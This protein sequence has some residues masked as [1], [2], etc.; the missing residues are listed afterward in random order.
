MSYVWRVEQRGRKKSRS[1]SFSVLDDSER[2]RLQE[3]LAELETQAPRD[4][5]PFSERVLYAAILHV[6]GFD[7]AARARWQ[8]LHRERPEI[9]TLS[10]LAQTR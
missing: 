2:A 8:A 7:E 4:D 9:G 1:G 6:N 10:N 5:A 3:R